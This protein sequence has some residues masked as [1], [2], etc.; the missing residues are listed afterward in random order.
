VTGFLLVIVLLFFLAR[1]F[2]TIV[3]NRESLLGANFFSFLAAF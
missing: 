3:P 1:T 2:R